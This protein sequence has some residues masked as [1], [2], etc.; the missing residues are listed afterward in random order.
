LSLLLDIKQGKHADQIGGKAKNLLRMDQYGLKV[1]PWIVLPQSILLDQIDVRQGVDQIKDQISKVNL[2]K[3]VEQE[4]GA[5][6]KGNREDKRFAVRSSAIDEDGANLSF[7]GQF[8]TYLNVKFSEIQ[9]K[10][11]L[12]WLSVISDRVLAYRKDNDLPVNYGIG[13]IVQ[14]MIDADVSGVAFGADPVTNDLDTKVISALYGLGEGLVSGDLDADTFVIKGAQIEK[15]LVEKIHAYQSNKGSSGVKKVAKSLSD[16]M[17]SSLT[18]H[19][20]HEVVKVLNVLNEKLG[21]PQDIE[22]AFRNPF[23]LFIYH[24][25]VRNG[26]PTICGHTWC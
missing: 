19:Q 5:F 18:D 11:K 24:Q 9:E 12:V 20:I 4:I 16:P 6:F 13:V 2:P 21:M 7:A 14:E 10:I 22:F 8:E 26:L 25:N 15:K 17:Q 23:D 3:E 1:P